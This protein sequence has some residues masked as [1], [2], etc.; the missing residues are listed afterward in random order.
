MSKSPINFGL[1]QIASRLTG[2]RRNRK[3]FRRKRI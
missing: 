3:N 1:V 2:G